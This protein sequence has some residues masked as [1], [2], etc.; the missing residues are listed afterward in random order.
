MLSRKIKHTM[1]D[2]PIT[3]H[4]SMIEHLFVSSSF[5]LYFDWFKTLWEGYLK[6]WKASLEGIFSNLITFLFFIHF[7][8]LQS[9][10][11]NTWS[12]TNHFWTL[13]AT[14][15]HTKNFSS[16]WELTFVMFGDLT[17]EHTKKNSSIWELTFVMFDDL[18]DEH[19]KNFRAFE[20]WP[21]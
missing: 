10:R 18:T 6:F 12:S 20:N 4:L 7:K 8:W 11:S 5:V 2:Q 21:L 15:E 19:T 16:V 17:D 3:D 14:D 9:Y 1:V 13:K